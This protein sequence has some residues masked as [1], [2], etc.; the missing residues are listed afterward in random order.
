MR[1]WTGRSDV[2]GWPGMFRPLRHHVT[3]HAPRLVLDGRYARRM[4]LAGLVAYVCGSPCRPP[5]DPASELPWC[6]VCEGARPVLWGE[7]S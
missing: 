5:R 3:E 4:R 7:K 2:D 6:P 1:Q